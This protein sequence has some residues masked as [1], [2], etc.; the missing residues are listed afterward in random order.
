MPED[1][2]EQPLVKRQPRTALSGAD[3]V[4]PSEQ[5]RGHLERCHTTDTA[6]PPKAGAQKR[7]KNNE[8]RSK[9]YG[10]VR[11]VGERGILEEHS[12]GAPGRE[13][14]AKAIR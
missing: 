1:P 13:A 9:Q 11:T 14:Y 7:K 6:P 2:V 12:V 10:G 4:W 8:T 5:T 3:T